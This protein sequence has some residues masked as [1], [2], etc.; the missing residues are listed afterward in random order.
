M[1]KK[2]MRFPKSPLMG[3]IVLLLVAGS[4]LIT[5]LEQ[6]KSAPNVPVDGDFY[7]RFIDVGQA[8]AALVYC[9]GSY[10]LID[11]GNKDDSNVIYTVLK[12]TG[13]QE[14]DI[15]VGTHAHEDHIGGLPGAFAYT[16]S[17]LTLC[18]VTDYDSTA[19]RDFR[20][21]ASEKGGGLVVPEEG[22]TYVLGSAQITIL[23]ANTY[24]D[25]N[26]TSIV[27]R[28]DYG[29]TSFLFTGDAERDVERYLLDMDADVEATVLK[30][31]H[32][33]SSTGSS[34]SFLRAC[35]PQYAI[36]S[37]G[38]DNSYGHPHDEVISRLNDADVQVFRTDLLGDI[39]C[40]SDGQNVWFTDRTGKKFS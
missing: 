26:N 28:V 32:H 36:I 31:A 21:S 2:S 34:Y 3:I 33:G 17:K 30:V 22:D 12:N 29:K 11:G 6:Q 18:P 38:T 20:K 39:L 8:D 10:M 24:E 9:E 14:L 13:V 19:F 4:W 7:V 16:T 27:L 1:R 23:A 5:H 37:C 15:V 40:Y 25:T 35:M